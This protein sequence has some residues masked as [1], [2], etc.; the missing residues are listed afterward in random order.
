[1]AFVL[2]A[3]MSMSWCFPDEADAQAD[4]IL[5]LLQ[6]TGAVVPVVWT[7]EI[8]NTL[9]VGE[10]R[11]RLGPGQAAT[12]IDLIETL[13]ISVDTSALQRA[14]GPILSLAREQGLASYDAAYLDLALV[15]RLPLATRDGTLRA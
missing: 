3:S 11:Q 12:F 7:L 9:L 14:F 10:R 4:G 8:A 6:R 5:D 15:L 13:P 1:M 2:D